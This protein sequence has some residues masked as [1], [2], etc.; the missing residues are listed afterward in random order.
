MRIAP[1]MSLFATFLI[2]VS[3]TAGSAEEAVKLKF[4]TLSPGDGPLNARALHPWAAR[5][6]AAG[7]GIVELD[8]RDGYAIANYDNVYNRVLDD[9]VQIAFTV[10]GAISGK[11]VRSNVVAMPFLFD[12]SDEASVAF[13]RLYKA[14]G[15]GAEYDEIVPLFLGVTANSGVHLSKRLASPD[16][17]RGIKIV[18]SSKVSAQ[19]ISALGATP[20][21]FQQSDMYTALQRKAVDGTL[22]AWTS[23]PPFKLGEVT[24]YHIEVGLGGA[25]AMVFMAKKT[26][27]AL[28]QTAQK[29]LMD[30]SGEA[31]SRTFGAYWMNLDDEVRAQYKT[32]AG[33]TVVDLTPAQYGVWKTKLSSVPEQWIKDT[34]G[35]GETLAAYQALLATVKAGR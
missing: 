5:V 26:F 6:N 16:D 31:Q 29:V 30:N 15:L 20:I 24:N 8:V 9:V 35:G 18:T 19:I 34:P 21:S 10:T 27:D 23:F 22:G 13:W 7:E 1:L 3:G 25:P 11:F 4:A 2:L 14:G 28:P 17:L 33:H 12:R 32:M